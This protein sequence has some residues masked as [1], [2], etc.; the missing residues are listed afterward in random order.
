MNETLP[1]YCYEL[2]YLA[3]RVRGEILCAV[4]YCATRLLSPNE[5]D[6]KKLFRILHSINGWQL[7]KAL[8]Y[9]LLLYSM[10]TLCTVN[11]DTP[12]FEFFHFR[13]QSRTEHF[14]TTSGKLRACYLKPQ[15]LNSTFKP[16]SKSSQCTAGTS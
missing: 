7:P 2:H 13:T 12:N 4:S 8:T 9:T 3:K 1:V 14:A 10:V 16:R 6:E 5:D 15:T 11:C